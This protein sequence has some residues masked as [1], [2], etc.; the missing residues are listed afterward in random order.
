M[1]TK[2]SKTI[3]RNYSPYSRA[4]VS[5]QLVLA[6][7]FDRAKRAFTI[8]R[9][10]GRNERTAELTRFF[11]APEALDSGP[12]Y[13][14]PQPGRG[15]RLRENLTW[16]YFDLSIPQDIDPVA[17]KE[18]EDSTLG[19]KTLLREKLVIVQ[20][21]ILDQSDIDRFLTTGTRLQAY[22][23]IRTLSESSR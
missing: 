4:S 10:I 11:P 21:P 7:T 12:E 1:S 5:S 6:G 15:R 22:A 3:R 9:T 18:L 16:G 13:D 17:V 8:L 23:Q 2:I 14:D 20:S 19:S